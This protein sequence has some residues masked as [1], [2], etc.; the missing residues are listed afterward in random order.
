MGL[1][2]EKKRL[3]ARRALYAVLLLLCAVIQ[4]TP[5]ALPEPFGARQF[6][7]VVIVVCIAMCE[8]EFCGLFFGLFAGVLLDVTGGTQG[9]NAILLT[10]F[11]YFCGLLVN[12]LIRNNVFTALLFSSAALLI[13]ETVYWLITAVFPGV[14]GAIAL[15]FK[16]YLSS[17]IYTIV[18]IPLWFSIVRF[19]F[20]RLPVEVNR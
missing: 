8:R 3:I 10:V 16:F 11:G 18:F 20:K 5:D 17:F 2:R 13:Y 4:N 6:G 14:D 15:F 12:N 9:I 1:T 7:V 19:I